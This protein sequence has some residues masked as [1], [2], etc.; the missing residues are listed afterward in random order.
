M[1]H[2]LLMAAV[3]LV[4][5]SACDT[6]PGRATSTST[7]PAAS[8]GPSVEASPAVATGGTFRY[9]IGEPTGITP[10]M[11]VS[12]DDRAVVD[13]VF[14]SLTTWNDAGRPVAAAA[15]SWTPHADAARWTFELRPRATF[16]DGTPVTAADFVRAW[17]LLAR[18]GAMSYLLQDVAGYEAFRSGEATELS[19]LQ[20]TD[21]LVLEVVLARPRADF[22][23]VVGHPALGP[24]ASQAMDA[25]P[26]AY[27]QMPVGN[28]PF[29][30]TE[31]WARGDF[32]RAARWDDWL[33]GSRAADGIAEVVF[34]IADLDINF[35]A[36][37]QG[38]RD[39][40][41]VPPDGLELATEEYPPEGGPW[42]GPGLIT[43]ARPEVYLL[44]INRQVPP[45]DDQ[46]VREAV[47]LIVDRAAIAAENAGGNLAPSTSLLPPSLPGARPDVCERCTYNPS[48]A[49]Q[50]LD[51]ADVRQL[52][53]A[54]NADGGHERIRDVLRSS[55]SG[56][57][58][59]LVSN[60]RLQAPS[61]PEYQEALEGGDIGLFRMPLTA[62]VPSGLSL[63]YPLLHRDQLP[64]AGG[65]NYLRYDDPTVSALLDQAARTID[66]RTREGLLRRVE[67]IAL[68][69]DQVVVPVVSY[70][71]AMVASDQVRNLRYSPF[72]LL[73]L[74]EL[75]LVG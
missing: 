28:G 15:V 67:D 59:G 61:L 11:A 4:T 24:V 66:D 8:A 62:D 39:L 37:S 23:I 68:N 21:P 13:A 49:R 53:I 40:T 44:A 12:A 71:H 58:V 45:Y 33:N 7:V 19:G 54:F 29:V 32:I 56:V 38:R 47:S 16:H 18:D 27:A 17:E 9:G 74:T 73:N 72:G 25:D 46:A 57:G 5:A 10:P 50:R 30:V 69:R 20:A 65:Q 42:D 43:G 60:G 1:R 22:P 48:A 2:L 35:L 26:V 64:E 31:P 52:T 55:L 41:A 6:P 75:I 34:R 63:L 51:E 36:F 3:L 70:Q 14:D